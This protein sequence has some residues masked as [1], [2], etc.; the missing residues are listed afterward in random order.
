MKTKKSLLRL[1]LCAVCVFALC[2]AIAAFAGC[3]FGKLETYELVSA[4]YKEG[5]NNIDY[6][7]VK[8]EKDAVGNVDG[9]LR[10]DVTLK[11]KSS[12]GN[13]YEDTSSYYIERKQ[14]RQNVYPC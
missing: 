3:A 1:M 8:S 4:E 9:R 2:A 5:A 7:F 11:L 6:T 12:K 13:E 10:Y 14:G